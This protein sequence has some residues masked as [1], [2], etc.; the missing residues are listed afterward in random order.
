MPLLTGQ[1]LLKSVLASTAAAMSLSGLLLTTGVPD[2]NEASVE[3]PA[4]GGTLRLA[5]CPEQDVR[6]VSIAERSAFEG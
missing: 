2:E 1:V 6:E 4:G 5:E 3:S